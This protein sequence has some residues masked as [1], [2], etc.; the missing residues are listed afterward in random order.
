MK[1]LGWFRILLSG[2]LAGIVVYRN[3]P[4]QNGMISCG[5]IS[6]AGLFIGFFGQIAN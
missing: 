2:Y 5:A 3:Y 6:L 1:V 4:D